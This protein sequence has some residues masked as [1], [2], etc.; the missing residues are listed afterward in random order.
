M[1]RTNPSSSEIVVYELDG[2]DLIDNLN[3]ADKEYIYEDEYTDTGD[4][5]PDEPTTAPRQ[6]I[7]YSSVSLIAGVKILLD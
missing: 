7:D 1:G 6:H 2:E 5:D 3:T 4:Y